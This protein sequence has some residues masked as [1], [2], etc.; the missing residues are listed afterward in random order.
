MLNRY[1]TTGILLGLL[2]PSLAQAHFFAESHTC[3][4]PNKPLE[5]ITELDKQQF[6]QQVDAYRACL[7]GFVD[8]QN[9]AMS[10]HQSAAQKAADAWSNYATQVLGAEL[11]PAEG[12][13]T[14]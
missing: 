7:Q 5:F 11:K 3:T 10:K 1:T 9:S 4:A 13:T 2:M 8:G 6:E 14:Q 12:V